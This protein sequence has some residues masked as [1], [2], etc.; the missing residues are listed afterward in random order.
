[1]TFERTQFRTEND[2]S[3]ALKIRSYRTF[4]QY[5]HALSHSL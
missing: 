4:S 3:S 1:M 2:M 5:V